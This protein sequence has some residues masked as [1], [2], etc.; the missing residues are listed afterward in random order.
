MT[1][2]HIFKVSEINFIMIVFAHVSC[3][4]DNL[5]NCIISNLLCFRWSLCISC[6][7]CLSFIFIFCISSSILLRFRFL[8]IILS[9]IENVFEIIVVLCILWRRFLFVVI[10]L[11][12]RGLY[13][14]KVLFKFRFQLFIF[15]NFYVELRTL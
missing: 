5:S 7:S 4:R 10:K 3:L 12:M 9:L 6:T 8:F 13:G 14:L 11:C 1:S 2:L 15:L